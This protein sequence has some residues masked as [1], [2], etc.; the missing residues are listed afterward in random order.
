MDRG[1][2]SLESIC[3]LLAYKIKYP[4]NFFLLRGNHE[5]ASINR[6]YGFYDEC[7]FSSDYLK[8]WLLFNF[9]FILQAKEGLISNYGKHLLIV[10]IVS[11][12]PPSSTKRFSA[13]TAASVP[14][15]NQWSKLGGSWDPQTFP[16][17]V[18]KIQIV[19]YFKRAKDLNG[20]SPLRFNRKK[21]RE[22]ANDCN[23]FR[24]SVCRR[25][26]PSFSLVKI[27]SKKYFVDDTEDNDVF[28]ERRRKKWE[29]VETWH[30]A[31][32]Y[33]LRQKFRGFLGY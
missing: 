2:Q 11:P 5:C 7:K 3:L 13:A 29:K 4:E 18:R 31:V 9:V 21:R 23:D 19:L 8:K 22:T 14:T 24:Q 12:S 1:K 33:E 17:R 27:P 20:F 10:S 30:E 15:S 6:I 26:V 32:F 28:K 16:T 25:K